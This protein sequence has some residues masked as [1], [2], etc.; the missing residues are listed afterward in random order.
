MIVISAFAISGRSTLVSSSTQWTGSRAIWEYI[1]IM[2]S[3]SKDSVSFWQYDKQWHVHSYFYFNRSDCNHIFYWAITCQT[4]AT[5][6]TTI[7]HGIL[8]T[9]NHFIANVW[10][11]L[12][13]MFAN[14]VIAVINACRV[15][16]LSIHYAIVYTHLI[17][18]QKVPKN[19]PNYYKEYKTLLT[20]N[21]VFF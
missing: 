15:I 16:L 19:I 5:G 13:H 21:Y 17:F 3:E 2:H 1:L 10:C 8:F 4:M 14:I 9:S 20:T 18:K 11:F 12:L 6:Y 7:Y